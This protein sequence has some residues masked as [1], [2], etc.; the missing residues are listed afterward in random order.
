MLSRRI[1]IS[2]LST[3]ALT[4][5]STS[6]VL[7][8]REA[9][10]LAP[11]PVPGASLAAS[12]LCKAAGGGRW[13][14]LGLTIAADPTAVDV[15][16]VTMSLAYDPSVYTFDPAASG[17][18]AMFSSGG[19]DAPAA[20]GVGTQP[21]QLLPATGLEPGAPLGSV[22]YTELPGLVTLNYLLNTPITVSGDT[23]F[24]IFTF[25]F[26]HPVV[27]DLGMSTVTYT[28]SGPGADFTQTA[29]TC[30]TTLGGSCGSNSPAGGMTITLA[31]VPELSTWA[32]ML[33][34]FAGLSLVGYRSSQKGNRTCKA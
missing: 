11:I 32:M 1:L 34:G 14:C 22:N 33:V 10:A 26:V 21:L 24:F 31:V 16:G 5:L 17:P 15:T 30:S 9:F 18:L 27:I 7:M 13:L 29:F 8:S 4:F 2:S 6:I 20:P 28:A 23:N 19:G 12:L 3:I 25:D